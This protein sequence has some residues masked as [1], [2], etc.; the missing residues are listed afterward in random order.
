[1]QIQDFIAISVVGAGLSLAIQSLK[2]KFGA[3]GWWTKTLT[4]VLAILV[5][6]L[7]IWLRSTPYF[8]TVM[9]VLGAA[10]VVYAFFLK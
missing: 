10:S 8:E 7:Y 6:G 3:T 9:T 5:G 2:V 1:M 4:L